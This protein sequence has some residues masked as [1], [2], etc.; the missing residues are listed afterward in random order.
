MSQ[1]LTLQA[2]IAKILQFWSEQGCVIHQGYDLEVGAGT[3]NPATFLRALGPE[4][5]QTAY[6]EPSR[7]P[8]DGRYGTHPNRLQNYHQLQV[9]LKPVPT[10][11]LS[12]YKD[13]L[14]IIGLDLREHDIR[15]VHDDWENPTI[16]AWG[17][18]WEVWLNGMEITQ[19]T[20]FQAI[21][22]K[23]LDT[24]SGEI[25]YGIERIAMYLQKKNSIFDVLWSDELTYGDVTRAS[26]KAWSEYN[27]DAANTQMWLK[28]FEDF[29]QEALAALDQG[30]PVPAYDFVIKASHAF[31]ILDARGVISVTER[32][33]Y[34]TRIRQLARAVADGYVD[35]R[36]SLNYPL[37]R[38]RKADKHVDT[39]ALPC[40]KME[41]AENFLLEIGAEELPATFVPIGIQQLESLAK[42]LL[43]DYNIGY[44]SL[45]VLG[46]PRRL[47][48]L[49]YNL[50]PTAIQKAV[51]KKGPILSSLFSDSG[52]VTT[53]GEQFFAT[54]HVDIRHYSEL[55]QHSL[56][57]IREIN[58]VQYLFLLH[59]EV[60][61]DTAV[62]LSNELP[63]LIQSMK[64]PK[65]MTYDDSGVEY[66]RP[67]R[68]LVSLYGTSVLPFSFGKVSASNI[69]WG[70]RQ[71]D[72]REVRI[73]SCERYID[74]L[75]DAC[76]I[77]S[78]KE[79]REIIEQG[80]KLHSSDSVSPITHPRLLEET[81]FLTEHPFVTCGQFDPEFCSLPKE[82][83]IA[84]M[85]NHQKYFPTQNT[86]QQI[87]NQF[88][89]VCDNC[90]NDIIIQG[91]E[92]ALTPR[93]TDGAFLFAQDLKT[94]LTTFVDKLKSVTYF[95][96]LGS[97]YD[98]VQ[99]LKAHKNI[100]YPLMPLSS[101]EDIN[102]AIEF[103]K[104]DLVSAVVNEF[105]ELQG[106]MGEYY[107]K[108]A[109]LSHA[110]AVAIG[111]H[112]RHITYGQTIST[113]GTLLSLLDRFDNLLSCFILNLRPTSSHD[114]YALRRQSLEILTLLHASEVSLDLENLLYHLADNFPSTVEGTSWDKPA[115]IKDLLA[116]IWGRLKTFLA[117]LGFSKDEIATVLSDTSEKNPVEII[118]SA[119]AIQEMKANQGATLEKITT[120]HNRLKKIL[121]SLKLP[122]NKHTSMELGLQEGRLKAALDQ[123]D[124][125]ANIKNKK[126]YFL[127]LGE[128]ADNINLFLNEV[129][130]TSGSEELKN[131][132]IHL[133]LVAMEKFSSY[134]WES[135]K[136]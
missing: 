111:E 125:S 59:P 20:Y 119:T 22:S 110:S 38:N 80:L 72:P 17:L 90:P 44:D 108:H 21:G 127:C 34:I 105:A 73:P 23:P 135:L 1:P 75:R 46:S 81:V 10:N 6:V 133:L 77:V 68:W 86:A 14:Q 118:K 37:L 55:S 66:A 104:A 78:H 126:E 103:C 8:Q 130:V 29:A 88:I 32:T 25:T 3:F 65:K 87:T 122:T 128:F 4:P 19:L 42:K 2:M 134:H 95:E 41:T 39:Q 131:L 124:A 36:A 56:F 123:F 92:K 69:S 100:V 93:L 84:E 109:G 35:W 112:L 33:R 13:S 40:P 117:S 28:H 49:I 51:E 116:F 11:F 106:I 7:R 120:T 113:T 96:A 15:F 85:V 26:E 57:D 132:R 82:L 61:K 43:S 50:E 52:D 53:Q 121:A 9:L 74:T 30:L 58:G 83:L 99:R 67:I 24:I 31:N 107:L 54:H 18:G 48:L 5:Y 114:P 97:L 76:V 12:L 63:K 71:L 136:S 115:V 16:G 89:L 27:F 62:I 70:H 91:N 94:P 102:T 129:H 101:E 79:R 45:E 47:A 64:F 60:R 98:K